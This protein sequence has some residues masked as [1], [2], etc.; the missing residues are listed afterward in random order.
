MVNQTVHKG[1]CMEFLFA[2]AIIIPVAIVVSILI[3]LF[4]QS[5]LKDRVRTLERDMRRM[6]D[7]MA[8]RPVPAQAAEKADV[9]DPVMRDSV[10]QDPITI[11]DAVPDQVIADLRPAMPWDMP[12]VA[13]LP[14]GPDQNQPLVMRPD[15]FADLATWLKDNWVYAISA[16][17]L[18]LA[19]VF[20]VQYGME[21][22]LLPPAVRVLAAV[23]FGAGLIGAGEWL[24][25]RHGDA[26]DDMTAYLPSVFSGAGLVSIFAA[27]LA[28]R[29]L[30]GL[31][32]PEVA[33]VALLAT[34][35]GAVVLGWFYGPLL[36]AVG[37]LGAALS[38][39]IVGGTA[40]A[41]P[42]LYGYYAVI[43]A[44]GLGVDA[45]RRW[46]WVSVLALVIG[47]GGAGLIFAAG[48]GLPGFVAVLL[49]L[50]GMAIVIPVTA[51]VPRHPGPSVTQALMARGATG[52]PAFPVRLAAGAATASSVV[53][54]L[55]AGSP[56]A[57]AMLVLGAMMLMALAYL[58]WAERAEGLDDLAALP[59]VAFV[60]SVV[61]QGVGYLPVLRDY[62]AQAIALRPPET[63]GPL[64][65]T[66]ILGMAGAMSLAAALRSFRAEPLG[67]A[68][69]LGAVLV[70][71]VT[72]AALEML[73]VP[74]RVI[75]AYPWALH[76]MVLAAA[77]V[78]L[79]AR[80][81]KL[82]GED[83]RRTAYA[84]L[85][86]MSLIALALF[87]L[88]SATA[89][90]LALAVLV[91]VA[92]ALDR[93]FLLPEM[94]IF[95]QIGVAILGY[96]LLV[97]PGLDWAL[98]APLGQVIV[99]FGGVIAAALGA[100]WLVQPLAR[101]LPK[102]VLESAAAGFAAILANVLI[103]RWLTSDIQGV[104][105][106]S[107]WGITLN[108]MPWLVLMLMQLH[109]AGLGGPLM[110]LRQG[111]AVV[112][113]LIAGL[114]LLTA[115]GPQ[116]P[117]S[118]YGP[119]DLAR[120]VTG[121]V[122]FSSLLLAYAIPGLALLIGAWKIAMPGRLRTGFVYVGAA[123]CALYVG[124]E[125]RH[126]WQ[127]NWIGLNAG[128]MQAEL[129]TYTLAMMLLG[130]V[131]LYLAI[132]QRSALLRRIAMGVIGLT[133]AKVFL[134]DASGL[135]G[136]TRVASFAGLGLSLAGL[137]W[138]NRWAGQVSKEAA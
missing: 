57:E 5:A 96:R 40:G 44:T 84:T 79:A 56:G 10:I 106:E 116:N 75:G 111:I 50:A 7:D 45:V 13:A 37:L 86:A 109:R 112:A 102:G 63:D 132:A 126:L 35:V 113:G 2:L 54:L 29:Q 28:A 119:E 1:G 67:I 9:P 33:F 73:W 66:L 26:A 43:A 97:D 30:Y 118:A 115:V 47:Y 130:A 70:A 78:A 99:T 94:G 88:T 90:T 38:P 6:R 48:A 85:S 60:A 80:Y 120:L 62:A 101:L 82:D 103:T 21:K 20:F 49:V 81:A 61:A 46:A 41:G 121:P 135:T 87:L 23:A 100:L 52:W 125:I 51:V 3:L 68:F 11:S 117:L 31:I 69:G 74:A 93:R 17:S 14:A 42:W 92:A 89:L 114:G 108:A 58:I 25:R 12:K 39:F 15:R 137:A 36:V 122:V 65:V 128:V 129:Y 22:G 59:A 4:G 105:L 34:A 123:L 53:L 71:P 18:A 24:R 83:H 72:A 133:V 136:L 77:M 32:G 19:G 27:V 8:A 138:L 110:R 134:L 64:T 16:V 55:L 98:E 95:I 76:M 127:G 104:Q 107:H 124:L 131:L 91:V